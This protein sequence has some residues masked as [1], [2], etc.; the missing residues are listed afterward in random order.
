MTRIN[1]LKGVFGVG[2]GGLG[3]GGVELEPLSYIEKVGFS[4]CLLNLLNVK[5]SNLIYKWKAI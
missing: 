5:R 3:G 2:G 4:K 1:Q